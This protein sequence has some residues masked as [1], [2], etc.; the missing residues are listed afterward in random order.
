MADG[1]ERLTDREAEA[2]FIA[3]D[4]QTIP[5]I[6]ITT[7]IPIAS[8]PA[9]FQQEQICKTALSR[10]GDLDTYL[11]EEMEDQDLDRLTRGQLLIEVTTA[12]LARE[13]AL[14]EKYL[15]NPEQKIQFYVHDAGMEP[16]QIAIGR[17]LTN[18]D[19]VSMFYRPQTLDLYRGGTVEDLFAQDLQRKGD[20]HAKSRQLAGH[21][22]SAARSQLPV[23]SMTGTH[24][25]T[26]VGIAQALKDR[27]RSPFRMY[28]RFSKPK[29][30]SVATIGEATMGQGEVMEAINQ[31]VLDQVPWLLI[32]INNNAG[33]SMGLTD[34]S[35]GQDPIAFARGLEQHGLCIRDVSATNIQKLFDA[36]KQI[37]SKVRYSRSPGILHVTDIFRVTD[38]TSSSVQAMFIPQSVLFARQQQDALPLYEEYLINKGVATREELELIHKTAKDLVNRAADEVLGRSV[39]P[40]EHLYEGIYPAQLDYGSRRIS[41]DGNPVVPSI[42]VLRST[43]TQGVDYTDKTRI[44]QI[45]TARQYITLTLARALRKYPEMVIYGEDVA[46]V[47]GDF[48]GDIEAYFTDMVISGGFTYD[49]DQIDAAMQ[50]LQ[51]VKAGQGFE[52]DPEVFGILGNIMRGKGGVFKN[53]Q[54]L[55]LLFGNDRV[56]NFPIREASIVGTAIGRAVAGELPV[57]EI[58]F[59]AYTSPAFAQLADQLSTLRWRGNSQFQAG[60]VVRIQ[61]M[62]RIGGDGITKAGGLGGIGHGAAEVS[63]FLYPGLLHV[64]PGDATETGP[65]LMEA[66]RVAHDYGQPVLFW[67]AINQYNAAVGFDQGITAHIPIGEPEI[68]RRGDDLTLIAWSNNVPIADK[69]ADVLKEEHG[70]STGVINLRTLDPEWECVRDEIRGGSGKVLIFEAGRG[71]DSEHV[72]AVIAEQFFTDLDAPPIRLFA[73]RIPMPAGTNN[74][75]Y[76]VPQMKNIVAK[77]LELVKY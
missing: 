43:R 60:M 72:G 50:A 6:D 8:E 58:Q 34:T 28:A 75:A 12:I 56:F 24:V 31:A 2:K 57:V 74:E 66:I 65:L 62:N 18:Q 4:I 16:V 30:I 10:R 64:I 45:L 11:S 42:D 27:D 26:S 39:E 48:W 36:T 44:G 54:F 52:V 25:L 3:R 71:A 61:G 46:T 49:E 1:A 21:T 17:N 41:T 70:I 14:R 19:A 73:R 40:P 77:A 7:P 20:P 55:Q 37:V 67:E 9:R 35:I 13:F 38:H 33:I 22:A 47:S 59:D 68:R 5:P 51:L 23:I 69:V 63:R 29:A 15:F 32:V 76:T 53:T